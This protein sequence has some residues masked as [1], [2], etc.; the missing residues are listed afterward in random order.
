MEHEWLLIT[1]NMEGRKVLFDTYVKSY[2]ELETFYH[3]V[4]T[5]DKGE[6]YQENL[7]IDRNMPYRD[8]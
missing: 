3:I 4:L 8:K 7:T 1:F 5:D 6:W 2:H